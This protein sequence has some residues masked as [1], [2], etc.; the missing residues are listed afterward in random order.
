MVRSR[1]LTHIQLAVSDL[2]RSIDFYRGVLG[3]EHRWA[4]G[5]KAAFLGTPGA[6]DIVTLVQTD[7]LD[8]AGKSGGV[9]HFG[10]HVEDAP[11]LERAL[12]AA[13][14]LGG[15]LVKRGVRKTEH[16]PAEPWAFVADPDGYVVEIYSPSAVIAA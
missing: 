1:G 2:K 8:K 15:R 9:A 7:A 6:D 3:L 12:E 10:F 11:D 14:S 16:C 5:E 13:V 4:G